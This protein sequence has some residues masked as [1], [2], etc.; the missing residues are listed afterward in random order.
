M[1]RWYVI[2]TK[3]KKESQVERL[4][5]EGGF[6]VYCPKYVH[7][8]RV[9]PFFPG[10]AFLRFEFPEQ[11]QMVKYTRGVKRVVGNDDGPTPIPDEVVHGIQGPGAGRPHRLREIRRGAGRRGRD[12]GRRGPA[13]GPQGRSSARRSAQRAGDDP[14]ELRLLPGH[15]AHREG[16]A[17]E[18]LV[19]YL[20]PS[21]RRGTAG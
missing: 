11:Y 20:R 9:G 16:Q 7:E 13:Q 10:Y 8:R 19:P 1:L 4:F 21:G 18:G 15:A 6:T 3:P 14:P 12:R 17:E 5:V 2:N